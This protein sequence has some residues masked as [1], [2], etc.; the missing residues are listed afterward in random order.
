VTK[1]AEF[2][3]IVIGGGA[4]GFYSAISVKEKAPH[5]SV[6]ILEK[7]GKTLS[8]LRISGGGRCNV[9][10]RPHEVHS[11]LENYPRGFRE[12]KQPFARFNA[13]SVMEW[14]SK[15]GVP[16]KIEKDG[17]VFPVS[18]SSETIAGL[19]EMLVKK[20]DITLILNCQVIA[21]NKKEN[22]FEVTTSKGLLSASKI[23][24]AAGGFH[25]LDH[26]QWLLPYHTLVAP[27]PSLFT[28]NI[29]NDPITALQG[30]SVQ[31]A[32]VSLPAFRKK[33]F[34]GPILI[35]H[36]GISGPAVLKLSSYAAIELNN[37]GYQTL[38]Q[39]NWLGEKTSKEVS[40]HLL[41]QKK[42]RSKAGIINHPLY[43]LPKRLWEHLVL[44][45]Q[46]PNS[47]NWADASKVDLEKL[48]QL[49]TGTELKMQGKTTFKEEFVTCGGIELKEIDFTNMQSRKLDGLFFAGELVNIDGITGGFNFQ[50]AWSTAFVAA[51]GITEG[52]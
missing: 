34:S 15:K 2:D 51:S 21:L 25:K 49:L 52:I 40:D 18:D 31:H 27:R 1:Q 17:R 23:V 12:L 43:D 16:L 13:A 32:T 36:W 45:A 48:T 37:V 9:T 44:R 24:A 22:L 28:F 6:C 30:V 42:Q 8:K 5:L 19:F 46:I 26:Y 41:T 11:F 29:P 3:I 38:V 10:H 20:H 50:S 14:F 47:K 4:A 7:T 33:T 39:V 35:T